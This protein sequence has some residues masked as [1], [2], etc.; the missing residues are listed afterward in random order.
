[1]P[2]ILLPAPHRPYAIIEGIAGQSLSDND[3]A[4]VE[5]LLKAYGALLF[6][7]FRTDVAQFRDFARKFCPTS[8]INESPGRTPIDMAHGIQSV[9]GGTEAFA[10]H[11]ELS[12][13]PW[14]PDAAFFACLSPPSAG[15][16]TTICDGI[17]LARALP[18]DVRHGLANRRLVYVQRTWPALLEF[19]L[20]TDSPS[21][22]QLAAPP[23]HCPYEFRHLGGQIARIFSRPALHRPLFSAE[24]AFG[25][26][27]LFSRFNNGSSN[28]PVLDDGTA[29]PE[30]WLQAIREAG[31]RLAVPI[32][33][34]AGDVLMLD[35]SRFMHGRTAILNTAERQIATF[36]GYLAFAPTSAE[37]PADPLWRR[38]DFCPPGRPA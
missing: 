2:T 30:G 20:G 29:V 3:A 38:A 6:R 37:E 19:W 10:L 36:F 8:V 34:Q 13:E 15:G 5:T 14:K 24:V 11:P 1:M 35:N 7:G 27:L 22:A 9:N 23:P 12:R 32:V 25:N 4:E 18:G 28:F 21:D 31:E 26:F 17:A 16:A 33:W